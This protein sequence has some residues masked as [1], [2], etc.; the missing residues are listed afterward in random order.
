MLG[1]LRLTAEAQLGSDALSRDEAMLTVLPPLDPHPDSNRFL[2]GQGSPGVPGE[3]HAPT[4]AARAGIGWWRLDDRTPATTWDTAEP[5]R[6]R[7]VW[8]DRDV[9]GLRGCGLSLLGVLGRTPSWAASNSEGGRGTGTRTRPH[10]RP[11]WPPTLAGWPVTTVGRSPRT[12]VWSDPWSRASRT[13]TAAQIAWRLYRAA[14]R[15]AHEADP[16]AQVVAGSLAKSTP[17]FT[18]GALGKG[19]PALVDAVSTR[20]DTPILMP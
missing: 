11:T 12:E 16:D 10:T 18:A 13:G 15:A 19:L 8:R 6:D 1:T 7:F 20:R 17:E 2:G 5:E 14:A 3:W 9:T 4:V